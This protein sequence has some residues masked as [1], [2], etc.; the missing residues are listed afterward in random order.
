VTIDREPLE[1]DGRVLPLTAL[2]GVALRLCERLPL[3]GD[4]PL[5]LAEHAE[6]PFRC[7]E[8][9]WVGV[10][11][12]VPVT[13]AR[14]LAD[15]LEGWTGK[16]AEE[17]ALQAARDEASRSARERVEQMRRAVLGAE[18]AGLRRQQLRRQH[19]A[20]RLR[21]LRALAR[22]LRC[23]GQRDLNDLFR[24][25]ISQEDGEDGRYH[26]AL[27]LLG[28]FPQWTADQIADADAF[29]E[30]LTPTDRRNQVA[31]PSVLDAALRDPRWRAACAVGRL[32]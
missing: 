8:A 3:T 7:V 1:Q 22:T 30:G 15:L 14:Q 25:Q 23:A 10:D 26:R 13:S 12:T 17:Q 24:H 21:L 5:V 31:L 29:A 20:A 6:G 18:K 11:R 2:D 27:T 4:V 19:E 9:R 16:P 32:H 28:G